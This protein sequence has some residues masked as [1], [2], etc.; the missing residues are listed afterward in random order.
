MPYTQILT[1]LLILLV[2]ATGMVCVAAGESVCARAIPGAEKKD[3]RDEPQLTLRRI[4]V[5]KLRIRTADLIASV[6]ILNPKSAVTIK[7]LKFNVKLN[8]VPSG[9]GEYE[10]TLKLPSKSVLSIDLPLTVDLMALPEVGINGLLDGAQ[11]EYEIRAEFDVP[12]L[13]FKKHVERKL[14]GTVPLESLAPK[15]DLP[16]LDLPRIELPRLRIPRIDWP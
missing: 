8:G 3:E 9:V 6:D 12:V 15:F 16:E 4:R 14:K 7:N 2:V 1:K 13:F 11:L 5:E 10:D